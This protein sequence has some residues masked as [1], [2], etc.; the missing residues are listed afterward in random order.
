MRNNI[1]AFSIAAFEALVIPLFF[2]VL[3]IF[4]LVNCKRFFIH[5]VRRKK[6]YL[7]LPFRQVLKIALIQ[8]NAP[9][10]FS[11]SDYGLN[12][13]RKTVGISCGLIHHKK[14]VLSAHDADIH[15]K[16]IGRWRDAF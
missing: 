10:L 7:F 9:E 3:N 16:Q 15:L 1:P 5:V 12:R 6:K 8:L 14:V 4:P 11:P 13:V 2:S